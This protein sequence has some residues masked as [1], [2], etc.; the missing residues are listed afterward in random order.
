MDAT[1]RLSHVKETE[2]GVLPNNK[3]KWP[4]FGK[5]PGPETPMWRVWMDSNTEALLRRSLLADSGEM[6]SPLRIKAIL[7]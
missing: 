6:Q 1:Q 2:L 3:K 5:L 4:F 7:W